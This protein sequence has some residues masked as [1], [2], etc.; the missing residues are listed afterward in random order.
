MAKTKDSNARSTSGRSVEDATKIIT[1]A[2]IGLMVNDIIIEEIKNLSDANE[3][4][5]E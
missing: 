3:V 1:T 2:C 5:Q 4:N